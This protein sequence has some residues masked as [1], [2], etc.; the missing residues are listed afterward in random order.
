MGKIHLRQSPLCSQ[1][2]A[3]WGSLDKAKPGSAR[4]WSTVSTSQ[5]GHPSLKQNWCE[6]KMRACFILSLENPLPEYQVQIF[7]LIFCWFHSPLLLAVCL[8]LISQSS[9]PR[10]AKLLQNQRWDHLCYLRVDNS[11]FLF[12]HNICQ[13]GFFCCKHVLGRGFCWFGVFNMIFPPH[14]HVS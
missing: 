8:K 12:H 7:S 9:F 13:T 2:I 14:T 11:V 6:R 5:L 4:S 10:M 3:G 1:R